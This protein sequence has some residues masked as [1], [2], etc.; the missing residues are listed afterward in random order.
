MS[1]TNKQPGRRENIAPTSQADSSARSD[2][3]LTADGGSKGLDAPRKNSGAQSGGVGS[4]HSGSAAKKAKSPRRADAD[5]SARP[6]ERAPAVK[7]EPDSNISGNSAGTVPS[8]DASSLSKG[9]LADA[10]PSDDASS[11]S[12]GNSADGATSPKDTRS[13]VNADSSATAHSAKSTDGGGSPSSKA[14]NDRGSAAEKANSAHSAAKRRP[15]RSGKG[16][17]RMT[18]SLV[19]AGAVLV[20]LVASAFIAV[21]QIARPISAEVGGKVDLSRLTDGLAGIICRVEGAELSPDAADGVNAVNIPTDKIGD[22]ELSL[23]FFGFIHRTVTVSVRDTVPPELSLRNVSAAPGL[24]VT[25][26][27]F[28]RSVS[29]ATQ[30]TLRF[31]DDPNLPD[32]SADDFTVTDII[33]RHVTVIA[34]DEGGNETSRDAMLHI[35]DPRKYSVQAELGVSTPDVRE[36]LTERDISLATADLS[37]IDVSKCGEYGLRMERENGSLSLFLVSIRDTTAPTAKVNSLDI[38]LG[39]S[40]SDGDIVENIVDQ[41][42]VTVNVGKKTL[43]KAGTYKIPVTLEDESGNR[44]ELEANIRVH[45]VPQEVKIERGISKEE[46]LALLTDGD[47]SL[48]FAP[49]FDVSSL[50]AGKNNV[51]LR[52]TY[53]DLTSVVT[54]RDTVPPVLNLR[55]VTVVANRS[56][57]PGDF[58]VSCTDA[59]SVSLSF[60][61]AVVT[62]SAGVSTVTVVATDEAGN[63]TKAQA[64]LTVIVDSVAPVIHGVKDIKIEL[65]GKVSFTSGVYAV[66]DVDGNVQL[67]VDSS[68]VNTA[69]AGNY[70]VW[71]SATDL[72]GNT[73]RQSAT[74]T[75]SAIS[76]N[77][78]YK[79]ADDILAQI[80]ND[81]MSARQKAWAIYTWCTSNIRYSTATSYLMGD[82][83]QG[84]YSGF[85]TRAGNCYI[86]Y[87]VANC[88]LT[89][90]GIQNIEISRDDPANPHYWN[91]VNIDGAWYHFDT[92]P[93]FR[94]APL[95]SFLLTDAEVAAYSEKS[96][97]GYYSFDKS[98]YPRTP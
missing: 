22:H 34:S 87:A 90:S 59:S 83:V 79:M 43:S 15:A 17:K 69:V 49:G 80:I 41:S 33:E 3:A 86:Y 65:G 81:K 23:T 67:N 11:L 30:I 53:S 47:G 51:T 18:V 52:G 46:L 75:V 98:K 85:R 40:I 77:T 32:C 73:A 54:V 62:S 8:D 28:V 70:T 82:F 89:R 10:T 94:S 9:N 26:E 91:M 97:P 31:K 57:S 96:A 44:T 48:S 13:L 55:D 42:S 35:V 72:S 74:V 14:D 63:V 78:V 64:T 61:G 92:C 16:R 2:G 12:E 36:M 95:T 27:D 84:A 38:R 68:A 50:S 21:S 4:S 45:D 71:Y 58:V 25:P 19:A 56:V 1:D 39:E 93:H 37:G 29:D 20:V 76:L 60:E 6:D 7:A 66:D 5:V 24:S 88:L